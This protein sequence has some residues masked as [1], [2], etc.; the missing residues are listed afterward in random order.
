MQKLK[1]HTNNHQTFG[2]SFS[3]GM[4]EYPKDGHSVEMLYHAADTALYQA[5]AAG[6]NLIFISP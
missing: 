5:K 3:G 2:I 6:R 4:A 1:F